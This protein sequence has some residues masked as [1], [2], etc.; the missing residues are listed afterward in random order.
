MPPL[1]P[2]EI[3]ARSPEIPG[4]SFADGALRRT[5][6]FADFRDAIAFLVRVAFDA[7]EADHHPDVAVSYKRLSFSL[8]T[9][10]EGGVTEKDFAL[11]KRIDAEFARRPGANPPGAG[12]P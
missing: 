8:S 11:A 1:S 6:V 4:W 12:S 7:E 3:L 2:A 9:H 10:S 5:L